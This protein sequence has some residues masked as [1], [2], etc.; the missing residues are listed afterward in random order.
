MFDNWE[1]MIFMAIGLFAGW[2]STRD[3][4]INKGKEKKDVKI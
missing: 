1:N 2:Y 3:W 4:Y